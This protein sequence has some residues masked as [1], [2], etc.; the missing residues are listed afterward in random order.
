MSKINVVLKKEQS[1]SF[2]DCLWSNSL[3]APSL[4][5]ALAALQGV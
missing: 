1:T 4:S 2:I 3:S 5:W